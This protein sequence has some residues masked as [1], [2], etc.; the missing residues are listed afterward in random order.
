MSPWRS[1]RVTISRSLAREVAVISASLVSLLCVVS[2]FLLPCTVTTV[3]VQI[4]EAMGFALDHA[5]C[6]AEVVAIISGSLQ[7]DVTPAPIKV[8]CR[9][10]STFSRLSPAFTD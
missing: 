5:E 6:A 2:C 3:R 1:F 4:K 7:K 10:R 8:R 9:R